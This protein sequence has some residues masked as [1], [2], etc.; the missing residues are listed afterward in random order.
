MTTE[1]NMVSN[2]EFEVLF[3]PL[4]TSNFDNKLQS[5]LFMIHILVTRKHFFKIFSATPQLLEEMFTQ[6]YMYSDKFIM[7]IF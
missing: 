6:Y 7:F 3:F 1:V 4:E 5:H 2:Q